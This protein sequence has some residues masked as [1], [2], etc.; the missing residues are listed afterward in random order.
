MRTLRYT[1]VHWKYGFTELY[2]RRLD[3]GELQNVAGWKQYRRVEEA[4]ASRLRALRNCSGKEC[5]AT[6]PALPEPGPSPGP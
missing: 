4:L 1:Y 6:F 2:D 5:R 3:P